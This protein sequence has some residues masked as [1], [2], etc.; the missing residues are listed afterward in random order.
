MPTLSDFFQVV[1]GAV[2][3]GNALDNQIPHA[4][5]RAIQFLEQNYNFRYMRRL[6]TKNVTSEVL[7]DGDE[8]LLLKK[9]E[10]VR[11]DNCGAWQWIRQVDPDQVVSNE[12][13][14]PSGYLH[15]TETQSGG[16][17]HQRLVFDA[18]FEA[19]TDVELAC[20]FFTKVDLLN[21]SDDT[22]WLVNNA[23]NVL[24][25]RTMIN[26]APIMREPQIMQMYMTLFEAEIKTLVGADDALEQGNR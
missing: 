15:F 6:I 19:A 20:Y 14:W 12:G 18:P 22:I 2:L 5:R 24:L 1:N 23:E 10:F 13:L 9:V 26:L 8:G 25:A 4:T 3:R 11:W 16:G 17:L 7:L 21:P